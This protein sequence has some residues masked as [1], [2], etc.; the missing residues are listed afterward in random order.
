[1]TM[2]GIEA[3]RSDVQMS[4][5]SCSNKGMKAGSEVSVVLDTLQGA[6]RREM[7]KPTG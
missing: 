6:L 3:V 5:R 2:W 1:M 4:T 7:A